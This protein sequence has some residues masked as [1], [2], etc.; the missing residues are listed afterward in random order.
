MMLDRQDI[1]CHTMGSGCHPVHN[2][3]QLEGFE[4]VKFWFWV[5]N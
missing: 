4:K 1:V 3:D 2:E 5:G